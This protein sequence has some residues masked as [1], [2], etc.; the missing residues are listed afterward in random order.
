MFRCQQIFIFKAKFHFSSYLKHED[1]YQILNVPRN[2]K[3]KDIK[4]SY[5]RLSKKYHPDLFN[6]NLPDSDSKFLQVSQAYEVLK[7]KEKRKTYDE[8]LEKNLAQSL[9]V[10]NQNDYSFDRFE[11]DPTKAFKTVF[12]DV[13]LTQE[14]KEELER[15]K[16]FAQT[17]EGFDECKDIILTL[18]FLQAARGSEQ[19]IPINS[20]DICIHCFGKF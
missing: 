15:K 11:L 12:K 14:L 4:K 19:Q 2:A 20:I 17:E 13:K 3:L 9:F 1:Y 5:Y 16:D 8:Y 6:K 18:S 10:K 7:D